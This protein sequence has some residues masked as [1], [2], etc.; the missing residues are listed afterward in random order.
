MEMM[1]LLLQ[2]TCSSKLTE[3]CDFST[4]DLKDFYIGAKLDRKEYLKIPRK[5]IPPCIISEFQLEPFFHKNCILFEVSKCLW[6]L[7]QAGHLSQKRLIEH[8]AKNGYK[9]NPIIPCLFSNES[10]TITFCLVV[11]DFGIR[12]KSSTDL[13]HLKHTLEQL[14]VVKVDPKGR[15]YLGFN[16]DFN[17]KDHTVTLSM[18]GYVDKMIAQYFPTSGPYKL[19]NYNT[20]AVYK[21]PTFG[22]KQA[23]TPV[24]QDN[25]APIT[26]PS[27]ILR[28]QGII[29]SS[30]YYARAVDATILE[31]VNHISSDQAYPTI[32][33]LSRAHRVVGYLNNHKNHCITYHACDMVLLSESDASL[34]SR[35][36]G[37]SVGGG[38]HK[39]GNLNDPNFK[40]GP[41]LC[42]SSILPTVIPVISEAEYASAYERGR[43]TVHLRNCLE[44]LGHSQPPTLLT[45]DNEVA[46]GVALET[47]KLHRSKYIDTRYHWLRDQ[48]RLG[49]ILVRW[50]KGA[51]N[52]AD[53]LTKPLP[54]A[55]HLVK[56]PYLVSVN[57]ITRS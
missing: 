23:Q 22:S 21:A 10:K 24:P 14:Y 38:V 45:C 27:L 11:D 42:V 2:S 32:D 25:S 6:G 4:M 50:Q 20:P 13:D 53:F 40:N 39:C 57:T 49:H 35:S 44:A 7:P 54:L 1:K 29:G 34:N 9:Q 17:D 30:L 33:L 16:I 26:D 19:R 31:A 55:Q 5:A 37:R 15:K 18:P 48:V 36:R 12:S 51:T 28:L 47:V 56:V 46:V 41:I 3:Q 8:L 43:E 52:I